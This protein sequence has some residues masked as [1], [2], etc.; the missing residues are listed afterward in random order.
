M[1]SA[2]H[3]LWTY[4]RIGIAWALDPCIL[5]GCLSLSSSQQYLPPLLLLARDVQWSSRKSGML[6]HG[7]WHFFKKSSVNRVTGVASSAKHPSLSWWHAHFGDR[8]NYSYQP[9]LV[10]LHKRRPGHAR[11]ETSAVLMFTACS[12]PQGVQA[13]PVLV[14]HSWL[15]Y[16]WLYNGSNMF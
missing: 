12:S 9:A 4:Q 13:A 16:C 1:V 7:G 10:C 2:S 3:L 11:N 15:M 6:I 5:M 14:G 8:I